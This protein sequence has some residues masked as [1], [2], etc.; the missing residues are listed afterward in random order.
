MCGLDQRLGDLTLDSGQA[1]IEPRLQEIGTIG[2]GEID[3]GIDG[4]VRGQPELARAGGVAERADEAGRPTRREELLRIG[5]GAGR[6]GRE[7]VTSRRPSELRAAPS[8]PPVVWVRP[9]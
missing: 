7:R 9:V 3:L 1:D 2:I 8:R 4:G 6:A 5:A